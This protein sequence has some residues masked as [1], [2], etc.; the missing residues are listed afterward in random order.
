MKERSHSNVTIMMLALNNILEQSMKKTSM[1]NVMFVTK[2]F[3]QSKFE[4]TYLIS[5]ERKDMKEIGKP[6]ECNICSALFY[7]EA[8][9]EGKEPFKFNLCSTASFSQ[10]GSL[11]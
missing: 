10:K 8:V 9:H 6:F 11:I 1:S 4:S 2:F 7:R 3:S 5:S